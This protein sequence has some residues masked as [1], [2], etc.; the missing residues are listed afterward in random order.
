MPSDALKRRIEMQ[1]REREHDVLRVMRE[2]HFRG[3]GSGPIFQFDPVLDDS[4]LLPD[5][6]ISVR[7]ILCG[8][9][10]FLTA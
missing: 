7:V 3:P 8:H 10:S 6:I 4:L 5:V 9:I 1:E 2:G